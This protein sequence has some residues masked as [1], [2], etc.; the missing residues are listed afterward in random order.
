MI[1]DSRKF[2]FTQMTLHLLLLVIAIVAL[3]GQFLWNPL[4]FDDRDFFMLDMDGIAPIS[5][6]QFTWLQLRSFPYE[7]LAL[8][9]EW[10][11]LDLNVFRI[12]NLIL[13]A[14]V[15]LTLYI[16]LAKLFSAVYGDRCGVGLTPRTA[17]F[18]SA[19]LFALHPV[20]IYAAGY[21]IQRS[22]VMATLFALL[23]L[24]AYVHGSQRQ[25][26]FWLWACVPLYYLSVFSKEH[27][28]M[29]PFLLLALTV[30]LHEDWFVKLRQ[31]WAIYVALAAVMGMV[32]LA[33]VN[34]LGS[35]YE[36]SAPEMLQQI[37]VENAYPLSVLTQSWLFFKYAL[38]WV[39]PNPAWMS[40]DMREPFASSFLSL[41]LAAAA[42][43]LAWG[44]VALWLLLKRGRMGLLGYALLFPW[45]MFWTEFSVVRI[46]ESFVLYR[47]YLWAVGAFCLLPLLFERCNGRMASF[48][49]AVVALAMMPI[50]MDR[51]MAF[52]NPILL[53]DDAEK[54]VRDRSELPGVWRIY[55]NRGT[56]YLKIDFVNQALPDLEKAISLRS[57][58]GEAHANYAHALSKV[59]RWQ[60]SSESYSQAIN[61]FLKKGLPPQWKYF[62]GRAM[63]YEK[64]GDVQKAELDYRVSCLLANKGCE[65]LPGG[66]LEA[67]R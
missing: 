55:Y 52:S 41:Y 60:E 36:Y 14:G 42:A 26:R 4:V 30:L 47:S 66:K 64:L 29:L 65:K 34:L 33:K 21:L 13:H 11:G 27:V 50:S 63:A 20:A 39:F 45:A 16:L 49:L 25:S 31:R 56:E 35:V 7:T 12:G 46:Q 38:L 22:T 54:L 24:L 17:A 2:F 3:Y 51:L 6:F 62:Y 8:T 53:W 44:A 43:Y 61:L 23:T 59:G 10:F 19:L 40:V 28:I 1:I 48:I 5:S 18:F 67:S 15:V 37:D 57:D 58:F 32:L 9:K